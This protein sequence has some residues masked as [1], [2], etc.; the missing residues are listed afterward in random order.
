MHFGILKMI[1]ISS[2]LTALE[3]TKV[4]FGQMPV[5]GLRREGRGGEWRG[6]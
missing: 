3:C 4:V 6:Q 1:A 5:A 2:F